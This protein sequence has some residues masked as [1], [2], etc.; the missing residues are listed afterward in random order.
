MKILKLSSKNYK[1]VLKECV[2]AL[3]KGKVLVC[4]TDT[5]YGL[6]CDGFNKKALNKVFKIKKREKSKKLP[7]FVKDIET[8]K[9]LCQV[10]EWQERF[11]RKVWPGKVTVVLRKRKNKKETLGL[12][13]P[14]YRFVLDLLEKVNTPLTGTSANISR[15]PPARNLKEIIKNFKNL[16][17][18]P[19]L[20]IDGGELKS[21]VSTIV[22]LTKKNVKILRK[23]AVSERKIKTYLKEIKK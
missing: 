6:V 13:I 23:G 5:V 20:I 14:N 17:L 22:D 18:K 4:P 21:S 12:R 7:L 8:A 1:K 15:Q 9:K 3:K 19:H 11:L 16:P 2:K 10:N